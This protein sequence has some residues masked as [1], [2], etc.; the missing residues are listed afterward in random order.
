M[1]RES[2]DF[3]EDVYY[4]VAGRQGA[5]SFS[6]AVL[7][8]VALGLATL[9]RDEEER[10]RMEAGETQIDFDAL[11]KA[12]LGEKA[13]ET[14]EAPT[15][16]FTRALYLQHVGRSDRPTTKP[17]ESEELI[18]ARANWAGAGLHEAALAGD[19]S[20]FKVARL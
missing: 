11:R 5:V 12:R 3:P 14:V 13:S 6:D 17:L 7:Q 16:S 2:V 9:E 10:R 15:A 8:V 1:I 4:K 20:T 19:V 18:Q